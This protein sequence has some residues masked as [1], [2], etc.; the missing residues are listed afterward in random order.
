MI[1]NRNK[2][3]GDLNA[4]YN[5]KKMLPI[6]KDVKDSS[7]IFSKSLNHYPMVKDLITITKSK[8]SKAILSK[9][10][11]KSRNNEMS[12]EPTSAEEK[13]SFNKIDILYQVIVFYY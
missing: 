10:N 8:V 1:M 5:N 3:I 7:L 9:L 12:G 4:E 6:I 13:S 2:S 11:Y